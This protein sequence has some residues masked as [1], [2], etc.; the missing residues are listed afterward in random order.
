MPDLPLSPPF[1]PKVLS[2]TEITRNVRELMEGIIGEV[3]V[4]GEI[5]N[6][7]KQSSGHQYFTLKDDRCQLPCVSFYRPGLRHATV[8]LAEGMLVHVRGLMTVY[9]ARGQYQLNVSLVQVAGA[10]L[11]QAKFDALK[12]KLAGEGLF[13]TAR[14]RA[15][16]P[17][18]RAIGIVTSP[19][20]AAI[21]DM[22]NILHR[23]APWIRIL[24]NPVR[25]QGAGAAAEIAAAIWE[26][27]SG[28]LPDVDVIVV[29]RGG[30]SAEDLWEFN[31]ESVARAIY[32]SDIPVVSAVG[33]EIDFTISDFVADLR[34]PTPSA[35]AELVAPDSTDLARRFEHLRNVLDRTVRGNVGN[36]RA[37]LSFVERSVL[38]REPKARLDR[39]AQ[40]IDMASDALGRASADRLAEGTRRLAGL[41]SALREHRPDQLLQMRRHQLEASA[42]RLRRGFAQGSEALHRRLE[43]AGSLLR[44]LGPQATLGR[45]YSI[46]RTADGEIVRSVEQAPAGIDLVTQLADGQVRSKVQE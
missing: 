16:P 36:W 35:A 1:A 4:E 30:G 40:Q 44:I 8:P 6:Y 9:E 2:V 31:E 33:H 12:R 42:E 25:V 32:A 20:G 19:T 7:R 38:F 15:L 17:F 43:H 13:E 22:L 3:W 26:F 14:K 23:R 37:Q 45:G 5:C 27:N 34:A 11:L 24:I 10:G 29:A 18:P 41:Q 21:Q 28:T 39:L 46:T